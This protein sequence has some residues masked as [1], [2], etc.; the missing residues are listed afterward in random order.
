MR[1]L[2]LDEQEIFKDQ[3]DD[4]YKNETALTEAEGE[5]VYSP[6]LIDRLTDEEVK[7]ED[8]E[9]GMDIEDRKQE[10]IDFWKDVQE[11]PRVIIK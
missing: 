4:L 7:P 3:M 8:V 2:T 9:P 5:K 10:M 11:G 1:K 6:K